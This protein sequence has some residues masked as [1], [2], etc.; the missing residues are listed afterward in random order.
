VT[1]SP[2]P[3][4]HARARIVAGAV[5][6][7]TGGI[8]MKLCTLT[9]WQV[10]CFR[11]GL[12]AL[13]LA[14]VARAARRGWT[15]RTL[16]VAVPYAATI[17]LFTLA[18]RATTAANA[19]FLQD[20]AVA[21]VVLLG[22]WLLG[23]RLAPRDVPFVAAV[24][25]GLALLFAGSAEPFATAP[26]PARGN[27][28]AAA[29]GFT[30]ALTLIGLRW[31]AAPP[32]GSGDAAL[33]GALAGN[34]LAALVAL[35]L[36]WPVGPAVATDWLLIAWL[37]LFQIALAYVLIAGGLPRLPA[38]EVTLLLLLEPVLSPIWAWAVLGER[39]A[40]AALAGGALILGATAL[41]ARLQAAQG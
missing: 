15:R 1:G 25:A 23:E 32:A 7:S 27:A 24:A 38:L 5:L 12:A 6:F 37:G 40:A 4:T 29:A 22:P 26:D 8:A 2:P 33:A 13:A 14:L 17:I 18:N 19:I 31:L 21:W 36:A 34:A 28:L 35:P 10:A 16:L 30:W 39:M 3:D 9:P 11:S 41:R 20:T